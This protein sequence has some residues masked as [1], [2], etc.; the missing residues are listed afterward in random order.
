MKS[1]N[2]IRFFAVLLAIL[3]LLSVFT[4]CNSGTEGENPTDPSLTS[5][6]PTEST[7]G[8]ESSSSLPALWS[9][10][11]YTESK[12]FGEGTRTFEIEVIAE[13]HSVTFTVSSD[14][15]Y[16]GAALLAH[17]IVTGDNG[18]YGLYITAVNGIPADY[19]VNQSWWKISKN[20]E[21]LMTGV[22]TTPIENGA[23]YE[24]TYTIG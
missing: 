15:E 8:D 22:D 7:S 24:L 6:D 18:D 20:G 11:A 10:A 17:G 2:T 5:G 9:T 16:L 12:T 14:E 19:S 13:G 21:M 1:N 23:H 4:A 3:T